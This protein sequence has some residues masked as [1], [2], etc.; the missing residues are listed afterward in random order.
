MQITIFVDKNSIASQNIKDKLL[1]H[2]KIFDKTELIFEGESV[3]QFNSKDQSTC[4]LIT[5]KTRSVNCE[6]FDKKIEEELS[7]KSDLIIFATTHTSKSQ[8]PS[9]SVHSIGN[10]S[11]AELGGDDNFLVLSAETF[12]KDA[13]IYME[14]NY[15]K[16]ETIK[17]FDI[18]QEV[19]H[20]GPTLNTPTI[21]IEIGSSEKEW[22]IKEAGIF[23]SET[24]IF[25]LNNAEKI[26]AKPY[27]TLFGIGGQHT[28]SNFKKIMIKDSKFTI[29]HICPKYMLPELT[30]E[31]ILQAIEKSSN[32]TNLIILDWKSMG[33][34][35]QRIVEILD[36]NNLEYKKSKEFKYE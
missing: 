6:N 22:P 36:K 25:L 13:L 24:I 28:A 33:P 27:E 7:I 11:K 14:T 10:W 12:L 30:E 16:F 35:K 15:Q 26:N 17:D 34:E 21:F 20:H 18:V 29:G 3:Y 32:D 9:L 23:I 8:I 5:T 31:N 2:F 19:T 1:N 4:Y